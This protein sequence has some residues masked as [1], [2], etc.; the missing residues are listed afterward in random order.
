MLPFRGQPPP[1]D[2]CGFSGA[3]KRWPVCLPS[4]GQKR[5]S[6]HC[7]AFPALILA[8]IMQRI[9]KPVAQ[10][11]GRLHR[12]RD[13]TILKPQRRR[14]AIPPFPYRL[15]VK[16]SIPPTVGLASLWVLPPPLKNT[17]LGFRPSLSVPPSPVRIIKGLHCPRSP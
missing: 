10:L 2:L 9:Q 11:L 16:A 13:M 1:L 6:K 5:P 3:V 12:H 17:Y 4:K 15:W 7:R 14:W 8:S